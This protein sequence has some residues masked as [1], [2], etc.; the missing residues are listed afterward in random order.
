MKDPTELKVIVDAHVAVQL[1][2]LK[3]SHKA[4]QVILAKL[5]G[6]DRATFTRK[7]NKSSIPAIWL[8]QISGHFGFPMS[9]WF[10]AIAVQV[11][12]I[13]VTLIKEK[14]CLCESYS[15]TSRKL[16]EV[17]ETLSPA[18]KQVILKAVVSAQKASSAVSRETCPAS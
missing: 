2:K 14:T 8:Y 13:K 10:P 11:T 16:L 5:V 15:D 3:V 7:L 4:N 17:V 6:V 1:R 9:H 18:Q 12:P